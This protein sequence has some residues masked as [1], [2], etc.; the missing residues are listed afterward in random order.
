MR[1]VVHSLLFAAA[2]ALA[3]APAHALEDASCKKVRFVDVGWSDI[4][5]TTGMATVVLEALGYN[6]TVTIASIPIAFAGMKNKQI[7]VFLGYWKPSMTPEIEPFIKDGHIQLLA[8]PNLVG[9][10]Y[11]LAVPSYLYDKGLKSFD[12]IAKFSKDLG[13]KIHGIESG[14]DGNALIAGM[15]KGNRFGLKDFK[16][17]EASEA[18]MLAEAQRANRARKAIV[19]LGWEPHPMNVQMKM[20]YLSGGDAVFGPEMGAATV[21]TAVSAGFAAKCPNVA[22]F[23]NN[24]QFTADM[25]NK[26]M[27]PILRKVKPVTAARSF[28]KS[29]PG[30]VE[31]WLKG[32]TSLD[33][34]DGLT[35]VTA[36]LTK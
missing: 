22:A 10:R 35:A 15:I 8:T 31:P 9:A 11:T 1:I 4:A 14:S 36:A 12:D 34:K 19:F 13:G 20:H 32:V 28:L 33:G 17:V 29:N 24:L 2:L 21:H 7:D 3:G 5:A 27:G 18:A 26:V 23:L 30:V 6:P 25:Q 16:L